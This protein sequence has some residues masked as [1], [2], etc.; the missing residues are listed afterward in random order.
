[1]QERVRTR[2]LKGFLIVTALLIVVWVLARLHVPG[3]RVGP[4][5]V[6]SSSI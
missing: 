3:V 4:A 1:M 5:V 6:Q 2:A